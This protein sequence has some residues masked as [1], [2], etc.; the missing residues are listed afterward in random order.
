MDIYTYLFK[1]NKSLTKITFRKIFFK[2]T[3]DSNDKNISYDI[4]NW[5]LLEINKKDYSSKFVRE[6][7]EFNKREEMIFLEL[8][9]IINNY[10]YVNYCILEDN[11]K[12]YDV[13]YGIVNSLSGFENIY[14]KN[15]F[16]VLQKDFP[17]SNSIEILKSNS[18]YFDKYFRENIDA[19]INFKIKN[20]IEFLKKVYGKRFN[21]IDYL[22]DIKSLS[23]FDYTVKEFILEK[24]NLNFKSCY[25][26]FYNNMSK[27]LDDIHLLPK[28]YVIFYN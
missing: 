24:A 11:L 25:L 1:P 15:G 10:N 8:L 27:V 22:K 17:K 13:D 26:F 14:L 6:V 20:F 5:G 7:R 9:N 18:Y 3:K 23:K 4:K 21:T 19:V 28:N 12:F 2:L 16:L